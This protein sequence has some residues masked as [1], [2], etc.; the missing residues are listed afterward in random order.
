MGSRDRRIAIQDQPRQ[1]L[2]KSYL[3]NEPVMV[4]HICSRHWKIRPT[5]AKAEILSEK[6]TKPLKPKGLGV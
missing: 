6:Q 4:V 5:H 1:K 2:A 3:K